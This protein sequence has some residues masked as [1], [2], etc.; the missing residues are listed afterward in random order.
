MMNF[1]ATRQLKE[2]GNVQW[3]AEVLLRS[4]RNNLHLIRLTVTGQKNILQTNRQMK[5]T[6]P[7]NNVYKY[8]DMSH[9]VIPHDLQDIILS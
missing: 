3:K 9:I 5:S 7:Q 8:V 6:N 4:W 1:M 2:A